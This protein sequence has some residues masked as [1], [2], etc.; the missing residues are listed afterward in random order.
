M[1]AD[2]TRSTFN[3]SKHY[4]GVRQQQ[5]RVSLD[6]DSNEQVDIA[7]HRVQIETSDVVGFSG[8]PRDNAGFQIVPVP[9]PGPSTDLA[10]SPGRIY[11]NGVL[12]ELESTPVPII[13][14]SGT[15]Q[16]QVTNMVADGR[17]F[18]ANQWVEVS[19]QDSTAPSP[20]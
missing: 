7:S 14:I 5:G 20:L 12:C 6:A 2:I 3:P 11:V 18:A 10:I 17:E 1:A 8:A 15:S 13:A 4:S 19:A 9:Q 16:A